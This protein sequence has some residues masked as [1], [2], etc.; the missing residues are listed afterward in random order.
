[1]QAYRLYKAELKIDADDLERVLNE[2]N[3][4]LLSVQEIIQERM[5]RLPELTQSKKKDPVQTQDISVKFE[6]IDEGDVRATDNKFGLASDCPVSEIKSWNE[7]IQNAKQT[8]DNILFTPREIVRDKASETR[9]N[10]NDFSDR[11]QVLDTFQE[12]RIRKR[13]ED[14]EPEVINTNVYGLLDTDKHKITITEAG[15]DIRKFMKYRLTKR[16][17]FLISLFS[18][19]VYLCGYIPYLINSASINWLTFGA[20][21][22]LAFISIVFLAAGGLLVLWF[23]RCQLKKIIKKYNEIVRDIFD[24]VNKSADVFSKYFSNICTYMYARSL[25]SGIELKNNN[26]Y[27]EKKMLKAHLFSIKRKVKKNM[28]ICSL[29]NKPINNSL[30]IHPY[31]DITESL[32]LELPS[33]CQLYEL[34]RNKN[35]NTLKLENTGKMF[36]APYSFISAILFKNEEVYSKGGE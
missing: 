28:D 8:I 23:M 25:I 4:N 12:E 30:I 20:A 17:I 27:T 24:N 1:L 7:Y 29:Y 3:E 36:D 22:G 35:K 31:A 14:I 21:L 26:D 19:L 18:L 9:K 6:H 15:N 34:S 32:L 5:Q 11:E 16:N 33:T 13:I 2:H 10:T